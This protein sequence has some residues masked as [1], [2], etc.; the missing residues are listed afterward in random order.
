MGKHK[1]LEVLLRDYLGAGKVKHY[2]NGCY[3]IEIIIV[4]KKDVDGI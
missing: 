1:K 4:A 2:E 3:A